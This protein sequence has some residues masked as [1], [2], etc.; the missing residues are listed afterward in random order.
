MYFSSI[1]DKLSAIKEA[2]K[3]GIQVKEYLVV[4]REIVRDYNQ[5]CAFYNNS[6]AKLS[7][8]QCEDFK[9]EIESFFNIL[10]KFKCSRNPL[11]IEEKRSLQTMIDG[12]RAIRDKVAIAIRNKSHNT[13]NEAGTF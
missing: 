10:N 9:N 1:L 5:M 2:K 11:T 7:A 3:Q 8:S 13:P 4:F 6:L 12:T